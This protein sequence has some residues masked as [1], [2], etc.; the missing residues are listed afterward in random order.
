MVRFRFIS[1]LLKSGEVLVRPLEEELR[2][3]NTVQANFACSKP[4]RTYTPSR[5]RRKR[6]VKLIKCLYAIDFYLS[7]VSI[8]NIAKE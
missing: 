4:S 8:S 7:L 1:T 5:M 6:M 3:S 2:V